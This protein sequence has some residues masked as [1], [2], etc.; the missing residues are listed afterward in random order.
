MQITL[1]DPAVDLS[2]AALADGGCFLGGD[3]FDPLA[4]DQAYR[5]DLIVRLEYLAGAQCLNSRS[6]HL[7]RLVKQ[8][9]LIGSHDFSSYL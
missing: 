5:R 1:F 8:V 2:A 7:I 3:H 9:C 6:S 4:T